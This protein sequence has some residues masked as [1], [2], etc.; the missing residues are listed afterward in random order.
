MIGV[1]M[2]T[3]AEA[4]PLRAALAAVKVADEPFVTHRFGPAGDRPGGVIVLSGIGK[5]AAAAAAEHLLACP[6]I[7]AV[8]NVGLCGA[9]SDRLDRGALVRIAAAVDG[10]RVL[11]GEDP[12]EVPC[13]AAWGEMPSARLAS[14]DEAVFDD[15]RRVQLARRADVVDM[16]GSAVAGVCRS[17]GVGAYLLKGVS[18]R[19]DG[20]GKADIRR[21][22]EAVSARLAEAVAGELGRLGAPRRTTPGALARFVKI[23][24]SLFSLPLLFAGAYLG[25]GGRWPSLWTLVWIALAGVGART[26]GMAMNRILDRRL[27]ALNERTAGRELPSGRMGLAAA[28]GIAAA[29]LLLYL[30]ACAALGPICLVLSPV[31]AVALIAYSL[32][33]RFTSLCHFGIGLCLALAPLG[34]F[35]AASGTVGFTAEVLLLAVFTFCWMSGFDI[36]YGLL[37]IESDRATG[38]RSVPAA[39]GSARAQVVAAGIHVVSAGAAAGLWWLVGAGA[40]PGLALAVTVGGF[41]VAYWPGLPIAAR[42]F[43][44]SAVVGI[45]ASMIPLLGDVR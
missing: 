30:L 14:V 8:V 33:K 1:L 36:I 4:E 3:A 27:D 22:I 26:L 41:V 19:A 6:A 37:D 15:D 20:S 34:A 39:L 40:L 43:P 24:H 29:A 10:D 23:E 17:H 7:E 42:F 2:A 35:V 13:A 18:D 25:A 11:A 5:H 12:E 45:A 28:C 38:V 21:N 16:E 44:T 32:L 9:L 31:P